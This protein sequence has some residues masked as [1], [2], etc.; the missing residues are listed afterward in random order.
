MVKHVYIHIPFCIRKC[1]Y[2]S[3]ISG[4]DLEYKDIYLDALNKQINNTYRNEKIKT[5]YIGGGTPSLLDI[6]DIKNITKHFKLENNSEITL[7]VNPETVD[8]IKFHK[9]REIGINRLSLGIQSF[10]DNILKSIGRNH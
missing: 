7:E 10:N 4:I 5:L 6:N 2:C 8:E 3:F 9:I 1:H